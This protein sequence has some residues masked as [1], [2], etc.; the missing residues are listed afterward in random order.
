[1]HVETMT[2]ARARLAM[3]EAIRSH[4]YDPNVGMV[5]FGHPEHGGQIAWDELAI[6]IHVKKKLDQPALE[7]AAAL[8][9]TSPIPPSI[10][11]FPT[12]IPEGIYRPHATPQNRGWWLP[13]PTNPHQAL[14]K[15]MFGGISI[16][17]EFHKAAGT[18][19]GIVI[20]R[21]TGAE[22]ILSNWHVLVCQWTARAGQR[23]YQPGRLDGGTF[24]NT[25]AT[26]TRH[27]MSV[28]L[29][30][31]VATLTGDRQFVINQLELGAVTGVGQPTLGMELV[32][33]GRT[34][35][36]TEGIV[37]AIQGTAKMTYSGMTR[38]LRDVVTIEPRFGSGEV[39][40]PGD[41][42]SCWLDSQTM[43][44]VG[45]HFAGSDFPERALA[46]DMQSVLDAL[47]VDLAGGQ[48]ARPR[49]GAGFRA[50]AVPQ[51]VGQAERE[52]VMR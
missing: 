4:L 40:R 52:L 45:L 5:D 1:M 47:N 7:M 28:N 17:D 41:S 44:A 51:P 37:T 30:A 46:L 16:S 12:D 35:G 19:G 10:G 31:A 36:V 3:R 18:L 6:R 25:V 43:Q 8:G 2:L 23:I 42:G 38:L 22:M 27:A 34:S 14:N 21:V 33:S 48:L 20:D 39:S 50:P 24:A 29:D 11:G 9:M 26:L 15:P 32:K 49:A 13:R